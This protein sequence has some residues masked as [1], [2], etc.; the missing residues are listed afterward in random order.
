MIKEIHFQTID[1]TN[2]YLKRNYRELDDLCFVSAE[3]QSAGRGRQQR[4]WDSESG[5]NLLFSV[6]IK[7]KELIGHYE[8][9]SIVSAYAI[10]KVLQRY[11]IDELGI[12]WPND[13]YAG[14]KKICGILLESVSADQLDCLIIGIGLNVNQIRFSGSY[15]T[16]PVSMKQLLGKD[17]KIPE[18]K[19]EIYEEL[20]AD[21]RKVKEKEDLYPQIAAY[22]ELKD[23]TVIAEI[24]GHQE[25][26]YVKG[27]ARDYSLQVID[28]NETFSLRSGEVSFHEKGEKI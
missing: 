16:E 1:S 22:D 25:K 6:L 18:L 14:H 9:L 15:L 24:R 10:L 26:V 20:L 3:Q 27:I 12:K 5:Q 4:S 21:F 19:N 2:S 17:I 28:G 23:K 11:G 7:E 8:E 13:V